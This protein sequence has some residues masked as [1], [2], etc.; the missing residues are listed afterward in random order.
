MTTEQKTIATMNADELSARLAELTV[1]ANA[2]M[3]KKD[4][5]AVIAVSRD[6]IKV[7]EAIDRYKK[8]ALAKAMEATSLLVKGIF[9]DIKV[10]LT[11][12]EPVADEF[13]KNLVKK[14]KACTGVE[15]DGA[16]G[17]WYAFNFEDTNSSLKL[18][19]GKKATG[20]TGG[21]ASKS[22]YVTNETS[23]KT[24][25]EEVGSE[26]WFT[27]AVTRTIDHQEVSFDA[28]TTYQQAWDYSANGGWR[29]ICRQ[30]LLK[31]TNRI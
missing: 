9:D 16:D 10:I 8:E 21:T 31:K 11:N 14:L 1:T 6:I 23:S 15:L 12:G 7:E 17:I 25:L 18:L 5:K 20:T 29:N 4:M 13:L 27:E 3:E 30:A 28:G 2:A 26:V 24:M 19:K 22:S